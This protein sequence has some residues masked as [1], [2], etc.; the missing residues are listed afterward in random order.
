MKK[1]FEEGA[2]ISHGVISQGGALDGCRRKKVLIQKLQG[3]D[4]SKDDGN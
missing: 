4:G 1:W 2:D 3:P